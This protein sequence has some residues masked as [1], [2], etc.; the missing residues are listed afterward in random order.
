MTFFAFATLFRSEVESHAEKRAGDSKKR[1]ST[2]L[3]LSISIVISRPIW[4]SFKEA[5]CFKYSLLNKNFNRCSS[6]P[7]LVP[8]IPVFNSVPNKNFLLPLFGYFCLK[9][10]AVRPPNALCKKIFYGRFCVIWP[11]FRPSGNGAL[12]VRPESRVLTYFSQRSQLAATC[13]QSSPSPWPRTESPTKPEC[14]VAGAG[15][16]YFSAPAPAP[17]EFQTSLNVLN[18]LFSINYFKYL[19]FFLTL[20]MQLT[21]FSLLIYSIY[22]KSGAGAGSQSRSLV[23]KPAPAPAL[24]PAK[25]PE[26]PINCQSSPILKL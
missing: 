8:W 25:L 6:R 13:W 9:L 7:K 19:A 24:A 5:L 26:W 4:I 1:G 11:K 21:F 2:T 23:K 3:S 16:F 15:P 17:G 14:S 18:Y 12:R 10:T 20:L 22:L